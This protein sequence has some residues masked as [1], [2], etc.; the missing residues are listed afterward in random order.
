VNLTKNPRLREKILE[1]LK[2]LDYTQSFLIKDASERNMDIKPERLSR[3]LKNKSGGL[4]EDQLLWVATRLGIFLNINFGN[5]VVEEG[6]AKFVIP[7][8]NE[9]EI[10]KKLKLIFPPK[11]KTDD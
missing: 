11:I 7:P 5:L 9:L 8:Y 3:Y 1:R 4:T 6:V 10:L 2:E